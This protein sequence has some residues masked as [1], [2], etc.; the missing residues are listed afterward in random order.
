MAGAY[1]TPLAHLSQS[2]VKNEKSYSSTA[3]T[4]LQSR[5]TASFTFTP[6]CHI[7]HQSQEANIVTTIKLRTSAKP[8][9]LLARTKPVT[10]TRFSNHNPAVCCM[11]RNGF[12]DQ[13][14]KSGPSGSLL[15]NYEIFIPQCQLTPKLT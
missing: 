3:P 11:C 1:S 7:A 8:R 9:N 10:I 2:Q 4:C 15:K 6:S 13:H 14:H 5:K 12:K